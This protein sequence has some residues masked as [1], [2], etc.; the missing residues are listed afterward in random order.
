VSADQKRAIAIGGGGL[1]LLALYRMRR[2]AGARTTA[3]QTVMV[4]SGS[5][6][7]FTPQP[8]ITVGAGESVYDPNSGILLVP[9]DPSQAPAPQSTAPSSPAYVVNVTY[10][11]PV[12][13]S[14]PARKPTKRK[15]KPAARRPTPP[16]SNPKVKGKVRRARRG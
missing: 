3:G 8:P 10:P 15:P 9:P 5:V 1:G 12:A 16:K 14:R 2:G 6:A 13:P 7:P 4:G 11:T